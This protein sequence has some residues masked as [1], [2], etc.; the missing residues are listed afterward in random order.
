MSERK[1][2]EDT[3]HRN[4]IAVAMRERYGK[5]TSKMRDRRKRREKD[6]RKS[7]KQEEW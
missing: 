6:A 3:E 4:P 2:A 5:T 7:W 1:D